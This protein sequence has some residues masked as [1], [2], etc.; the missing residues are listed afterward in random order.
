MELKDAVGEVEYELGTLRIDGA[1]EQ[2]SQCLNSL[3]PMM[4]GRGLFN[5]ML[6]STGT[7]LP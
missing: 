1:I 4:T 2:L 6:I 7:R 5:G 3:S